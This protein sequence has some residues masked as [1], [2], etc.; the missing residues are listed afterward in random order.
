MLGVRID[1][2]A[3]VV[4][5][6]VKDA[7]SELAPANPA[8]LAVPGP[9]PREPAPSDDDLLTT[10]EAAALCGLKRNTLERARCT[11]LG[12]SYRRLSARCIRYR[13]GDV[14]NW[15]EATAARN[16]GEAEAKAKAQASGGKGEA[17]DAT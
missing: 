2:L 1:G 7:I 4:R 3:E 9:A 17:G 8:L 13:R 6:A 5:E 14:R 11:G 10:T 16:T 15:V 12:P